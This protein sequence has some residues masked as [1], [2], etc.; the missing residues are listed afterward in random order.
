MT[1]SLALSSVYPFGETRRTEKGTAGR[2]LLSMPFM[3]NHGSLLR[4]TKGWHV[5]LLLS[6]L[7]NLTA[8]KLHEFKEEHNAFVQACFAKCSTRDSIPFVHDVPEDERKR[9]VS[10]LVHQCKSSKIQAIRMVG[11]IGTVMRSE[12]SFTD[13]V[14]LVFHVDMGPDMLRGVYDPKLLD[15]HKQD[16]TLWRW[17]DP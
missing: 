15:I 9:I 1:K 5:L 8:C 10:L 3:H 4:T 12:V 11:D 6:A 7:A 17:R 16:S 2:W 14:T 13:G